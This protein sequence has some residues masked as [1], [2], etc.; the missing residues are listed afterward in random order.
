MKQKSKNKIRTRLVLSVMLW[1]ISVM[2]F[3]IFSDFE[4]LAPI[5]IVAVIIFPITTLYLLVKLN[6]IKRLK[7]IEK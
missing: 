2:L 5:I 1:I 3:L 6:N 4:S 7:K